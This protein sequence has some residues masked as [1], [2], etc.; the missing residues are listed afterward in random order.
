M[1][2][3]L[4]ISKPGLSLRSNRT[5]VP[6]QRSTKK[7]VSKMSFKLEPT[8]WSSDTG[9]RIPCFD[10]TWMFHIK[11]VPAIKRGMHR[12]VSLC[13]ARWV[14]VR[15]VVWFVQSYGDRNQIF[16]HRWVTKFS[17]PCYSARASLASRGPL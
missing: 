2:F 6:R 16:S 11:D 15:A 12:T 9:P 17:Y 8:I 1:L 4:T 10:I 5:P 7:R 13:H 14:D 3:I